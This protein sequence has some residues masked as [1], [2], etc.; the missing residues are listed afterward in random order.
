MCSGENT[1]GCAMGRT[2]QDVLWGEHS[3]MC[4]GDGTAGC[5]VG[6]TQICQFPF[7]IM[8]VHLVFFLLVQ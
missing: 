4:S 5:V 3:R 2:Q 1:A 7:Q 8:T 6:R